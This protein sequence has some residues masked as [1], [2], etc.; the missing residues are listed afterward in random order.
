MALNSRSGIDSRWLS[1]NLKVV[2]SF[3]FANIEIFDSNIS[4]GTYNATTN[5]WTGSRT[6]LWSGEARI[7]PTTKPTNRNNTANPTSITEVEVHFNYAGD[8]DVLPGHQIFVTSSPYNT[9]L[10]NMIFTVRSSLN[11]SN[12]WSRTLICEVDEEVRRSV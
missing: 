7:Q 12:P 2:S 8:L 4:E 6:V 9:P 10:T 3:N 11:S 1:H 5:T